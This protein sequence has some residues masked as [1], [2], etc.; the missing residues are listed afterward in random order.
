MN[1]KGFTLVEVVIVVVILGIIIGLAVPS[2]IA[3]SNNIKEKNYN[4]KMDNIKSKALEYATDNNVESITIPVKALIEEGY[5]A[6]ENP[7][8][9]DNEKITNPLGGYLDCANI[10]IVRVDDSYEIS[11]SDTSNCNTDNIVNNSKITID[12]Y[13]YRNNTLGKKLGSNGNVSWTNSDKVLLY[14]NVSK[15]EVIGSDT[16]WNYGTL[17]KKK[18]GNIAASVISDEAYANIYVVESLVFLDSEYTFNINTN[19][20]MATQKVNVKI[21]RE[22]PIANANVASEWTNG[23]KKATFSGSDGSGSGIKGF[24]LGRSEAKP[25]ADMFNR[26]YENSDNNDYLTANLDVGKY[27]L[28]TLDKAGNISD[29]YKFEVSGVDKKGPV[30]KYSNENTTWTNQNLTLTY[31]CNN[32]TGTGC[33]TTDMTKTIDYT[34]KTVNINWTIEDN[35]GNKTECSQLVNTFVDKTAPVCVSSGGSD[36]WTNASRTLTGTCSDQDSGCVSNVSKDYTTQTEVYNQSAG[37]VYDKAGNSTVCP[38]N[39]TVKIDKT[40]PSC[41]SSG[42][43][44]SWTNDSRTLVGTCSDSGGSVCAGN[45]SWNINWEGEWSNLSP[46]KVKDNAGNETQ[47][48][49]N[50]TVKVDKTAPVCESSGGSDTW[51]NASRT[52][53]GTCSDQGS[54]CVSNVSKDYTTQTEVYNQSAG[55][56]YDKAGNSTVCPANQTVKIDKTAPSCSSSGG[57]SS[58]TNDSRTLVGTCSDSGGSVCAGN[59]SWNINWEG[60]WSNL[61]PGK[62]KDNAGNETQCPANQSVKVD[63]TA[64]TY[65]ISVSGTSYNGGY[66]NSYTIS[67]TCSDNRSGIASG[68]VYETKSSK[69]WNNTAGTCRDNA[70]N[71]TSYSRGYTVY[72]WEVCSSYQCNPHSCNCHQGS[73]NSWTQGGYWDWCSGPEGIDPAT[74]CACCTNCG[75]SG[76]GVYDGQGCGGWHETGSVCNGYNTECSTCY[77][78]CENWCWR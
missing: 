49:A 63:K 71:T 25:T 16:T 6:E 61:S 30:C 20:G 11:F 10:D 21:D 8:N 73:C 62:V 26:D 19:G 4:Q 68:N 75:W 46:G 3:V 43:S 57:S 58:W 74:G 31:G 72:K 48:P 9:G 54:G 12:V 51:T 17:S 23:N 42:G 1:K 35:I 37:T 40:A 53:I 64:P 36:T 14:A 41:S 55:T 69:G 66:Q 5:L 59:V 78:T 60:E 18:S 65:N 33:K 39:Q 77:D 47:C 45:V 76:C 52:L 44:S 32:D 29:A 15:L 67:V 13:E 2:Y 7:D 70:G 28:Y 38:A 27:Y 56:V 50:Q 34:V 22:K 24:Y